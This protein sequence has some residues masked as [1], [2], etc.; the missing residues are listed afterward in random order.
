MVLIPTTRDLCVLI[1]ESTSV[2]DLTNDQIAA[3][4]RLYRLKDDRTIAELVAAG[5]ISLV[6]AE[7]INDFINRLKHRR[8][9]TRVD[10]D[11]TLSFI[12]YVTD[13]RDRQRIWEI[14]PSVT[15]TEYFLKTLLHRLDADVESLTEGMEDAT[16]AINKLGRDDL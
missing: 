11:K 15:K 14:L 6:S 13:P 16:T 12:R 1:A 2:E 4:E 8:I 9:N 3:F 10:F 5:E 7:E